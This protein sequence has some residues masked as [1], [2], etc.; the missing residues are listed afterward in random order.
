MAYLLKRVLPLTNGHGAYVANPGSPKAYVT[1]PKARRFKTKE[2][3]EGE[4][5][6]NEVVVKESSDD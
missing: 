5:C 6:G 3:A 1:R 4:A 2:Q